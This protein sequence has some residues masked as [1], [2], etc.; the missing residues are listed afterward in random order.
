M[1]LIWAE[2]KEG[3]RT[4]EEKCIRSDKGVRKRGGK[5]GKSEG[6]RWH[7][8]IEGGRG[9]KEAQRE[10]VKEGCREGGKEGGNDKW[11]AVR[12]V[13]WRKGKGGRE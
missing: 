13:L 1:S 8:V 5:G 9:K 12:G 2:G 4:E 7:R 11:K 10:G 3:S 6:K